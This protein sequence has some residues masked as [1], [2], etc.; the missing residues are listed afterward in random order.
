[1]CACLCVYM[2]VC[3]ALPFTEGERWPQIHS[4]EF[5]RAVTDV[6]RLTWHEW[7]PV[8]C[9]EHVPVPGLPQHP[10]PNPPAPSHPQVAGNTDAHPQTHAVTCSSPAKCS[11]SQPGLMLHNIWVTN[12]IENKHHTSISWWLRRVDWQIP[13][14]LHGS[15]N[16]RAITRN[17]DLEDIQWDI[18]HSSL[19]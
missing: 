18:I 15:T 14:L 12:F 8:F 9:Q 6:I 1:M 17:L 2:R 13:W 4:T 7:V 16:Y 10:Q 3:K 5:L 19:C 11:R